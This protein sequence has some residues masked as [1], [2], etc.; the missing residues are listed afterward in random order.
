MTFRPFDIILVILA[1]QENYFALGYKV[2][3]LIWR[4]NIGSFVPIDNL[5][6]YSVQ[7]QKFLDRVREQETHDFRGEKLTVAYYEV[8]RREE[9]YANSRLVDCS[10]V[11][12]SRKRI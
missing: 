11:N 2:G 5:S 9:E 12:C 7:R 4:P 6:T 10:M 8:S 3:G 1:S